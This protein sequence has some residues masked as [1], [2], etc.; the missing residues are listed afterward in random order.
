MV[1]SLPGFS[2]HGIFQARV[3]EWGATAFSS[4]LCYAVDDSGLFAIFKKVNN[5]LQTLNGHPILHRD[6]GYID[7]LLEDWFSVDMKMPMKTW[8]THENLPAKGLGKCTWSPISTKITALLRLQSVI[9]PLY[10][11]TRWFFQLHKYSHCAF[12]LPLRVL[13]L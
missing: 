5:L 4:T 1:C 7:P 3:L 11:I 6:P 8:D 10:V 9:G 12:L 2:I 13:S